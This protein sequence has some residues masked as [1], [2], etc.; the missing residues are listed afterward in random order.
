MA[1]RHHA[2]KQ[3]CGD[4]EDRTPLKTPLPDK[5]GCGTPVQ[6]SDDH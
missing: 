1:D 2:V 4:S 6:E 5:I 3:V